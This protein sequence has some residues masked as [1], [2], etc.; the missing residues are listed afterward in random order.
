MN[1][2]NI[3]IILCFLFLL[4][5]C[6]FTFNYSGKTASPI[7]VNKILFSTTIAPDSN[8]LFVDSEYILYS[9]SDNTSPTETL[10]LKNIDNN[11]IK[12]IA[13]EENYIIHA[14][15]VYNNTIYVSA[16]NNTCLKILKIDSNRNISELDCYN[17][18][19]PYNP[20]T[21]SYF[22][23]Y[24]NTLIY[25]FYTDES[26]WG[27]NYI[28]LDSNE[29]NNII[30]FYN[31]PKV[32]HLT[33]KICYS[34]DLICCFFQQDNQGVFAVFS[35]SG[36]PI[37]KYVLP[38]DYKLYDFDYKNNQIFLSFSVGEDTLNWKNE[39]FS[40]NFSTNSS[41]SIDIP[42]LINGDLYREEYPIFSI[43]AI[44]E[45]FVI[46]IDEV[47]NIFQIKGT[48]SLTLIPFFEGSFNNEYS[49]SKKIIKYNNG[50]AVYLPE[51]GRLQIFVTAPTTKV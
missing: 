26:L 44:S 35:L 25:S 28:N 19:K 34:N 4:L 15:I 2:K 7:N 38:A 6:F 17:S 11:K 3:Y 27:I 33:N 21:A 24:G 22:Q 5:C 14:A 39:I 30:T 41:K 36:T 49:I 23:F 47:F 40:L 37:Y 50:F 32:F 16:Y 10:Y 13:F 8:V 20:N 45:N 43:Y 18:T 31:Q 1:K 48:P 12:K 29:K 51:D 42:I 9:N 46:G